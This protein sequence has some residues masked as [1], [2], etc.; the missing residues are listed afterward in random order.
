[1]IEKMGKDDDL[2][3]GGL[4]ALMAITNK[5]YQLQTWVYDITSKW[6]KG[7][8]KRFGG[9][10]SIKLSL[11]SDISCTKI[12]FMSYHWPELNTSVHYSL[13]H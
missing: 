10:P 4:T 2:S 9:A 5:D 1:M 7:S 3:T 12:S 8:S 11:T 6:K 13:S